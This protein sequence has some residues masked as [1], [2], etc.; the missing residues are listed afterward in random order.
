FFLQTV[1]AAQNPFDLQQNQ[2]KPSRKEAEHILVSHQALCFGKRQGFPPELPKARD[3][4]LAPKGFTTDLTLGP[5]MAPS[6]PV[7]GL[8]QLPI[9]TYGPCGHRRSPS[10]TTL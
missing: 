2:E 4:D 1:S 6:N 5:P 7:E 8:F 10:C 3:A 9:K